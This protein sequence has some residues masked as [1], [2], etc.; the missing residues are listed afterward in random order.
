MRREPD[1]ARIARSARTPQPAPGHA[2]DSP[3]APRGRY[4]AGSRTAGPTAV[5]VAGDLQS[6]L[7]CPG[8]WQPECATT[9]LSPEDGV[10]QGTFSVPAGAW[11]YKAPLNGGW[12]ENYG[13]FAQPNGDNVPLGLGAGM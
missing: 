10:W 3:V 11:L 8:D 7:G 5:T 9:G 2:L 4:G 12:D 13:R 1:D 6:E